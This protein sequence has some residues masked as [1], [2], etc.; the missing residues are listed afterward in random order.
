MSLPP[1][2]ALPKRGKILALDLGTRRVGL[3]ISD[4]KQRVAF[5]RTEIE[6]ERESTLFEHLQEIIQKEKIVGLLVGLPLTLSGESSIQTKK[7]L[8]QIQKLK[9][10]FPLPIQL[11]DERWTTQQ[12]KTS[13]N[14]KA[15]LDSRAAQILLENYL[16]IFQAT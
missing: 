5:Q 16:D 15:P 13:A 10:I 8:R 9:T 4:E 14:S 7:V 1:K 2:Q 6:Y 11:M 3:A 12:A